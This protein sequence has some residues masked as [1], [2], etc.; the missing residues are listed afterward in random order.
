MTESKCET[1]CLVGGEEIPA[2]QRMYVFRTDG[3]TTPTRVPG[4]VCVEHGGNGRNQYAPA[5]YYAMVADVAIAEYHRVVT[6]NRSH[7][8]D[9]YRAVAFDTSGEAFSE[10]LDVA[11]AMG[12]PNPDPDNGGPYEDAMGVALERL[13]VYY[14]AYFPVREGASLAELLEKF[15]A[16]QAQEE[17]LAERDNGNGDGEALPD[18]WGESNDDAVE[19]LK[20]LAGSLGG[21]ERVAGSCRHESKTYDGER[22]TCTCGQYWPTFIMGD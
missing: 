10:L 17:S 12:F 3:P 8:W 18:E 6:G 14:R 2:H 15:H 20:A 9:T 4:R 5:R 7:E 21:M 16:W 1:V 13:Q 11:E 19:L 22:V